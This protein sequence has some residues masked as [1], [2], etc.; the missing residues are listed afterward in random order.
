MAHNNIGIERLASQ[1]ET[2]YG[3]CGGKPPESSSHRAH[4]AWLTVVM[5]REM[6]PLV[7]DMHMTA[8][9]PEGLRGHVE[10]LKSLGIC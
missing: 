10:R 9:L 8:D 6:S 5:L 4:L 7:R 1:V 3:I 2:E